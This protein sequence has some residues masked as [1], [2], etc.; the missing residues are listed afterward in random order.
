VTVRKVSELG[1]AAP[2]IGDEL[3]PVVQSGQSRRATPAQVRAYTVVVPTV[4][5]AGTSRVLTLDDVGRFIRCTAAGGCA[6]ALPADATLAVPV[7]GVIG[8]IQ[9]G[10][11]QVTL[12]A[13]AGAT[14]RVTAT[15]AAAS[16][17]QWAVI[18]AI[19]LAAD[20]WVAS[21]NLAFA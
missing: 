10:A 2:L 6:V 13:G 19:K 17:E 14:L 5:E 16:L 1:A 11:A 15:F 18:Y 8:L 21:G 3:I 12:S 20:T 7:G 9:E 4:E